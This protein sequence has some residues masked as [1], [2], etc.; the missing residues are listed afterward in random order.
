MLLI[1]NVKKSQEL[2]SFA[3]TINFPTLYI[4]YLSGASVNTINEFIFDFGVDLST[5]SQ[6]RAVREKS[7]RNR[8]S[9]NLSTIIVT[10]CLHRESVK[11]KTER[12][13]TDSCPTRIPTA[14]FCVP[15][16]EVNQGSAMWRVWILVRKSMAEV[17]IQTKYISGSEEQEISC[18]LR[19]T[20][21]LVNA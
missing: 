17:S 4:A 3:C 20:I 6:I 12:I 5:R 10:K 9:D 19:L 11:G 18:L 15:L 7:F 16:A 8:F 14:I 1:T 13:V 2:S 21:I